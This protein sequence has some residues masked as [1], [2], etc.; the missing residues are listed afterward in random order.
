MPSTHKRKLRT[1]APES[2]LRVKNPHGRQ[3][4]G[5]CGHGKKRCRSMAAPR[6]QVHLAAPRS[7]VDSSRR[8]MANGL[9]NTEL[10]SQ[11]LSVD[12]TR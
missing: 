10:S 9:P 1:N 5:T 3:L 2:S 8:L 4:P 7:S 6:A 12:S 11:C